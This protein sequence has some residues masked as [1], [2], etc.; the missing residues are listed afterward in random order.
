M[1]HIGQA[2]NLQPVYY[3]YKCLQDVF[4]NRFACSLITT[5]DQFKPLENN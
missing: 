1:C 2:S 4:K 5:K 3:L